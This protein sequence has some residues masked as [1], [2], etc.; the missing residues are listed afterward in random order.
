MAAG[1]IGYR[2]ARAQAFT[3]GNKRTAPLAARWILD[4]NGVDG[5]KLIPPD[6]RVL[7][8][9]LVQAASG[10]DVQT[11]IVELLERRC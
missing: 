4:H 9:L 7:A 2:I 11:A 8:D 6:D 3:D 1:L 10:R 5:A